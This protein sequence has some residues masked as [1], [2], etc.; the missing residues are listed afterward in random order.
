LN[1]RVAKKRG[2]S[3]FRQWLYHDSL[4][5]IAELDGSGNL[6]STFVYASN[7]DGPDYM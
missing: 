6:I 3:I 7:T 2:T 4:K 1:R 5:P